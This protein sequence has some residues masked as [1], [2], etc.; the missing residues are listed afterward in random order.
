[1]NT[2]EIYEKFV[3]SKFKYDNFFLIKIKNY[4][5]LINLYLKN[6]NIEFRN[7]FIK[8]VEKIINLIIKIVKLLEADYYNIYNE[9]LLVNGY[10][11]L[12]IEEFLKKFQKFK[13]YG[14]FNLKSIL[15]NECFFI[16]NEIISIFKIIEETRYEDEYIEEEELDKLLNELLDNQL[17]VIELFDYINEIDNF[18]LENKEFADA[19][20]FLN[21]DTRTNKILQNQA[22]TTIQR[23]L[24]KKLSV[25][26]TAARKIQSSY[27][28]RL[29]ILTNNLPLGELLCKLPK[30]SI[31][32]EELKRLTNNTNIISNLKLL[33]CKM[34]SKN[35]SLIKEIN[36]SIFLN[37]SFKST[38]LENIK[39]NN[40]TFYSGFKFSKQLEAMKIINKFDG[41]IL[42]RERDIIFDEAKFKNNEFNNCKF[43]GKFIDKAKINNLKFKKCIFESCKEIEFSNFKKIDDKDNN[44]IQH[45][46]TL[47]EYDNNNHKVIEKPDKLLS[48]IFFDDC[49]FKDTSIHFLFD[50]TTD[51]IPLHFKDVT[52]NKVV[53]Y[54]LIDKIL[55]DNCIFDNCQFENNDCLNVTFNGCKFINI[56]FDTVDFCSDNN[57][58]YITDS[59]IINCKFYGCIF[60]HV[61]LNY[62]LNTNTLIFNNTS[63]NNTTFAYSNLIMFKFNNEPDYSS[64]MNMKN[65]RFVCND[66]FGTN[67]S[68]C[69][70]EGSSFVATNDCG[71]KI[72]WYGNVFFRLPKLSTLQTNMLISLSDHSSDE[73]TLLLIND[74]PIPTTKNHVFKKIIQFFKL[75]ESTYLMFE[76]QLQNKPNVLYI[77]QEQYADVMNIDI[78]DLLKSNDPLI[79]NTKLKFRDFHDYYSLVLKCSGNSFLLLVPPTNFYNANIKTCNFQQLEGFTGFD[80]TQVSQIKDGNRMR[81]DLNATNFT[82]CI[83]NYANFE[84]ANIIGTVFQASRITRANFKNTKFNQHTNFQN[85]NFEEAE[86]TNHIN[87]GNLRQG[88]NETHAR[89][90]VIIDNYEK[91]Y[92]FFVSPEN[93]HIKT[94]DNTDQESINSYHDIFMNMIDK[95]YNNENVS[96]SDIIFIKHYFTVFYPMLICKYLNLNE[97][98]HKDKDSIIKIKENFKVCVSD[99]FIN[100][101]IKKH[102]NSI[103]GRTNIWSWLELTYVSMKFLLK[104]TET[105]IYTFIQYYFTEVFNAHGEGSKSCPLGMIERLV[106]IHSQTAECYNATFMDVDPNNTSAISQLKKY[107]SEREDDPSFKGDSSINQ[108]YIRNYDSERYKFNKLIILTK[109]NSILPENKEEDIGFSVDSNLTSK[110]REKV[111]KLL[112]DLCNYSK[113]KG[114]PIDNLDKLCVEYTYAVIHILFSNY[115]Y[116]D[117]PI[118]LDNLHPDLK[119]KDSPKSNFFNKMMNHIKQNIRT[120]E[121]PGFRTSIIY[122]YGTEESHI[123]PENIAD[124]L[125]GGGPKSK[126]SIQRKTSK[127][128]QHSNSKSGS[129]SK[130]DSNTKFILL[131]D[132]L[133]FNNPKAG[134]LQTS[135]LY[136]TYRDIV[137]KQYKLVK[138]FNKFNIFKSSP[139]INKQMQA[140]SKIDINNLIKEIMEKQSAKQYSV[141]KQTSTK[142]IVKKN[143]PKKSI[144]NDPKIKDFIQQ[145]KRKK[146]ERIEIL[147]KYKDSKILDFIKKRENDIV[148]KYLKISYKEIEKKLEIKIPVLNPEQIYSNIKK[149][150]PKSSVKKSSSKTK[151]T[152]KAKS[153]TK[154]ILNNTLKKKIS[155][156]SSP[157][158]IMSVL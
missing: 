5:T 43:V 27:K 124:Y 40:V 106:L 36:N 149:S 69:D 83:M 144:V 25:K 102:I 115:K 52:F 97:S 78:K 23:S 107:D 89:A 153:N 46:F 21:I 134:K 72:N 62:Y 96:N 116:K 131:K 6:N 151:I 120:N 34:G 146:N 22:A 158:D 13:E 67:F 37:T 135:I 60:N 20:G 3:T 111:H 50:D 132:N 112:I 121:I 39:F 75:G 128:S 113:E 49:T 79:N 26:Q 95:I 105:Y 18:I 32:T 44:G 148:N 51:K 30:I 48:S 114:N 29:S 119:E 94:I 137:L 31:F 104:Q 70:L 156:R 81:P 84:N 140:I 53:F 7:S 125:T 17:D 58:T 45:R 157:I 14:V 141:K 71:E 65:N 16:I 38:N 4:E 42:N 59:K 41:A 92:V 98:N 82:A 1:M 73:D 87:I 109:P 142:L 152:P 99:E 136:K 63:I 85:A 28:T 123:K 9:Y 101:L 12:S 56:I 33:Y 80:F 66:L 74:N 133:M 100:L 86:N 93:Q 15:N 110:D 154:N 88:A 118:D 2:D 139:E 103:D 35:L 76:N 122:L 77:T 11:L 147:K 55:F 24:R 117:K 126:S 8:K 108:D 127:I 155:R 145:Q 129:I 68:Y 150:M 19:L 143:T 91:L 90:Q 61:L 10:T 130:N 138:I 47:H 64:K 54:G 57:L